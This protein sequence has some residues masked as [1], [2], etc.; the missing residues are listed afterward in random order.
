[1]NEYSYEERH[2][3]T[4]V[5]LSLVCQAKQTADVLAADVF[6]KISAAEQ[7]FSRFLPDSSLSHLN[8]AGSLAVSPLFLEVLQTAISLHDLTDGVFN[9]L[10]QVARLG[11][12][13]TLADLPA[14][15]SLSHTTYNTDIHAIQ[16]NEDT[17]T[18]TLQAGQQLDFGGIL[19]G[20]LA[21]ELADD[22]MNQHHDCQGC[23]INIGGDVTTRGFDELHEPFIFMLYN[24]VTDEDI[25]V[26]L[27]DT[28]LA[29]SG[30]YGRRWQTDTGLKHHL[31]DAYTHDNPTSDLV[32][33]SSI[34]SSGAVAEALTKLFIITGARN[35]I[36]VL[37]PHQLSYQYFCV[38]ANGDINTSLIL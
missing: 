26:P 19:K 8:A 16:I 12:T 22:V 20:F 25:P 27:T 6:N 13:Q 1:M 33:V 11:Y 36:N 14:T 28:S 3:G 2:M 10:T 4:D 32:A 5:I 9:P 38:A 17:S 30:T 7:E 24:P 29:T 31:V 37:T 21:Q 34:H 35:A 23:I 18:V 15:I